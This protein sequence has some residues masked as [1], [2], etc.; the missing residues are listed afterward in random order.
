MARLT[1]PRPHRP[2]TKD[3]WWTQTHRTLPLPHHIMD[4][5]QGRASQAMGGG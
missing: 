1:G 3:G 5:G 2:N 4:E